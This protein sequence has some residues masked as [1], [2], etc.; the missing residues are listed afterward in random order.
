MGL[1]M[2]PMFVAVLLTPTR[3]S[4]KIKF[5]GTLNNKKPEHRTENRQCTAMTTSGAD[6]SLQ[7]HAS[8]KCVTDTC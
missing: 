5:V 6:K 2:F 4:H 1:E 7:L 3:L 8:R